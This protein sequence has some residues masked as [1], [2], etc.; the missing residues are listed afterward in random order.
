MLICIPRVESFVQND[1]ITNV[2]E[3]NHIGKIAR[4]IEIPHKNNPSYKRV[5]LNID[6]YPELTKKIEERFA[7]SQDIKI[8]HSFPWFW[9][10]VPARK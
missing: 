4:I 9:K 2:F 8:V 10:I 1:Y 3:K 6:F 5:I 7:N